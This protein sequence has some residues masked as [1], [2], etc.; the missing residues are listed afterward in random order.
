[1]PRHTLV[2]IAVLL[3]SPVTAVAIGTPVAQYAHEW[4]QWRGPLGTGVAPYANPPLTWSESENLRWKVE[5]PGRGHASPIVWGNRVYLLAAVEVT[6]DSNESSG[7]LFEPSDE[8]KIPIPGDGT[9]FRPRGIQPENAL[10]FVV[11]ALDRGTGDVLWER[12]AHTAVPHE[13]THSTAT[14]ASA[15][16]VTDGEVLV[17][18]FGSNGVYAYDLDGRLL[19]QRDL[20]DQR[21]RNAFGEGS[22]PAIHGSSVVVNWDHEGDSFIVALDRDSGETRWRR[23]RDEPT[24]WSTPL[25]IDVEGRAQVVVNASNRVRAYDLETGDVVW[26]V[27]GMTA[28]AIPT[29]THAD[30]LVFVMSGFRGNMLMAIRVAG[31]RG[32]LDGS[33]HV[34][35]SHERD[36]SY[37]PSGLLYGDTFYFLKRNSGILSNLDAKTG[38]VLFGPERLEGIDGDGGVY[39]SPVGAADRVYIAARNGV[40]L[41]LARGP[42]FKI[43][44]SNQLDDAFDAS[45]A[46]AG[47]ELFLRGRKHLYCLADSA[48]SAEFDESEA[49]LRG[50]DMSEPPAGDVAALGWL[51]GCWQG[52][53]GE[54]CWLAPLGGTMLGVN[55]GP[56]CGGRQPS[57]EFLR[58]IEQDGDLV[59]LASPSGRFPPTAFPAVEVGESRVVFANP[60]HDFPQRITYW[61]EDG[62]NL[63]ARVEAQEIGEWRGFDV[64]W[65][66]AAKQENL[67]SDASYWSPVV[68]GRLVAGDRESGPTLS[69]PA[70]ESGSRAQPNGGPY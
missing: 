27:G 63:R 19:W 42:G 6:S 38:E 64:A 21:T 59:Y 48:K 35:W 37:T 22:S 65:K 40:T 33:E 61:L 60:E 55:R 14:W 39:A 54:E 52:T 15:S 4:P 26:H 47:N 16:A 10:R 7:A 56:E 20:G 13:G 45:P 36:T 8:T 58:I 46:I 62:E 68:G 32:D 25:V 5:L 70:T 67:R 57:F 49:S 9:R 34:V 51:S 50:S 66:R 1:M 29:P 31:A 24:S 3:T 28:N 23:E 17:A 69:P 53:S 12:T 11:L 2:L 18:S 43:L 44:A 41:V 30:G